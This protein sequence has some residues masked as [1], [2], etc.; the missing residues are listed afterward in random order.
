[1]GGFWGFG[2]FWGLRGLGFR[3][4]GFGVLGLGF[5]VRVLGFREGLRV[6]GV[7]V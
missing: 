2:V 5:W 4:L 7:R 6:L 1:M 3:G